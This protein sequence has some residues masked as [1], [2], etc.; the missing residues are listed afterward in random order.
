MF[1]G[2]SGP[3]LETELADREYPRRQVTRGE[4]DWVM[5]WTSEETFHIACGPSNLTE[6]LTLFRAWAVEGAA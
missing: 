2:F 1:T 3:V 4:H 5:A 6:A